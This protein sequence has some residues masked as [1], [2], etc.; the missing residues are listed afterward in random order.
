MVPV[1]EADESLADPTWLS[2]ARSSSSSSR[3]SKISGASGGSL[4]S[5]A[6]A[7]DLWSSLIA[8]KYQGRGTKRG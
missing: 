5:C 3:S 2:S 4:A 6:L 8:G 7:K 1:D